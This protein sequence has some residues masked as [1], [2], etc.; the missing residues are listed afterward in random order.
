MSRPRSGTVTSLPSA[1]AAPPRSLPY[2]EVQE[3][4]L[5]VERQEVTKRTPIEGG[6]RVLMFA[7]LAIV[8]YRLTKKTRIALFHTFTNRNKPGSQCLIGDLADSHIVGLH[9]RTGLKCHELMDQAKHEI[10]TSTLFQEIPTSVLWRLLPKRPR[11]SDVPIFYT[12]YDID[13]TVESEVNDGLSL[14]RMRLPHIPGAGGASL[15]FIAIEEGRRIRL[16]VAYSSELFHA[17]FVRTILSNWRRVT[18]ELFHFPMEPVPT[19]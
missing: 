7:A 9:F 1:K 10:D 17:T 12:Y 18:F 16:R 3:L 13:Y 4:A 8:L 5:P 6:A 2:A 14:K 19:L 15:H 11:F